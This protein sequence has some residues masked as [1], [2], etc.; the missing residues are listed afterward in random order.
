M[1]LVSL[2]LCRSVAL[3]A[4]LDITSC[5]EGGGHAIH[6]GCNEE[7]TALGFKAAKRWFDPSA[8]ETAR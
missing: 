1:M 7:E 2:W 8:G 3:K 6:I 5:I 4:K